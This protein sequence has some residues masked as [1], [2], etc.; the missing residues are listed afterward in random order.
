MTV[1]VAVHGLL[2]GSLALSTHGA[3]RHPEPLTGIVRIHVSFGYRTPCF[4]CSTPAGPA[5]AA[6]RNFSASEGG[7]KVAFKGQC[8][9]CSKFLPICLFHNFNTFFSDASASS[10]YDKGDIGQVHVI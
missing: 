9:V 1:M 7:F 10:H 2:S 4:L 5:A 6:V 8:C 3:Y